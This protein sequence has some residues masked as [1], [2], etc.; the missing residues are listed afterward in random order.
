MADYAGERTIGARI[1]AA[2]RAR[3]FRTAKDLPDA[4]V[5]GKLTEAIIENIEAGRK[6]DLSISQLFNIAMALKVPV[7]SLASPMARPDANLDLPNLSEAFD[8]MTSA[9]FDAWLSSITTGAYRVEHNEERNDRAELE[10][11][12]ELQTLRREQR[13]LRVM[14]ELHQSNQGDGRDPLGDTTATRLADLEKQSAMIES[15]LQEAG[16]TL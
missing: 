14:L 4:I 13:R 6:A 16:W 12:R 3:G 11:L 7:S 10:L 8:G 2:R 15:H 5:G 9:Q 1:R